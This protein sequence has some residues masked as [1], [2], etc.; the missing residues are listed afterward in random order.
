MEGL[1]SLVLLVSSEFQF[2]IPFCFP[3]TIVVV[4]EGDAT[5]MPIRQVPITTGGNFG[6]FVRPFTDR[7]LWRILRSPDPDGV[8]RVLF[9]VREP[10]ETTAEALLR[11]A[12]RVASNIDYGRRTVIIFHMPPDWP[13]CPPY[14]HDTRRF[15][16]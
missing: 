12:R 8:V 5:M 15:T 14:R 1:L 13:F 3:V 9:W 4:R 6:S 11:A 10:K 7:S 2:P 16:Q